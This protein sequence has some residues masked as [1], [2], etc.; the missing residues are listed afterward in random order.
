MIESVDV[1]GARARRRG[2]Q[3]ATRRARACAPTRS[4]PRS[5]LRARPRDRRGRRR[6]RAGARGSRTSAAPRRSPR[7]RRTCGASALHPLQTFTH[8]EG[9][10]SSTAPGRPS[11]AE[12]DEARAVATWLAEA[13]GLRPFALADEHG[14]LYHAGA[15]I[16]SN[17]LV[18]LR[19]AAGELLEAPARRR[20]RSSR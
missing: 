6:N 3:R 7:S 5:P 13:L 17:Y 1:I 8:D 14:A 12:S 4:R 20:R 9:R 11:P 10:S 18:T 15:A 19:R 16:A 2:D